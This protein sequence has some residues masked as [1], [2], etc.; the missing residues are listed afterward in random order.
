[1]IHSSN[2]CFKFITAKDSNQDN[3]INQLND[4]KAV[5]EKEMQRRVRIITLVPKGSFNLG[6]FYQLETE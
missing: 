2:I 3:C 5:I 4:W 1:M 6:V